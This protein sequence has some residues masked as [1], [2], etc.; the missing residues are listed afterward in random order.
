MTDAG[1]IRSIIGLSDYLAATND[2]QAVLLVGSDG[3]D[4]LGKRAR[5]HPLLFRGRGFPAFRRPNRFRGSLRLGRGRECEACGETLCPRQQDRNC[6][7]SEPHDHRLRSICPIMRTGSPPKADPLPVRAQG[8]AGVGL[9]HERHFNR[10]LRN[11]G[12]K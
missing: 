7:F 1:R 5:I 12:A 4:E 8:R 2:Q 10:S 9:E 11:P 6:R 3:V